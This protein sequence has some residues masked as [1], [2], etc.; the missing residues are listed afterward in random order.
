MFQRQ[1]MKSKTLEIE[2]AGEILL[3][4][5]HRAK[6]MSMTVRF[7]KGVRVAV[8]RG[9]SFEK[10]EEFVRSKSEWIKRHV[11]RMKQ[12]EQEAV[13]LKKDL[14]INRS[15]ARKSLVKRLEILSK[16]HG[17]KYNRVFIRKQ[18]TRWGSCSCK[19]NINLNVNLVLLPRELMDYT[20]LHELVHTRIKDHSQDFWNE[21]DRLVGD[22]RKMNSQLG[23]YRGLLLV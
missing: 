15:E 22:A 7:F 5:S 8:P 6:R 1:E 17:Y 23:I 10:A 2:E 21:L 11:K 18:K 9:I 13:E 20:I 12:W 16:R 19:N 4:R 14:Q 3:E